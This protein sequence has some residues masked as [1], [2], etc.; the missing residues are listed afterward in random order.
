M[1]SFKR[2]P[3]TDLPLACEASGLIR[4]FDQLIAVGTENLR[5]SCKDLYV[6][7]QYNRALMI[8]P[9]PFRSVEFYYFSISV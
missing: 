1:D 6:H 2:H 8:L 4:P 7:V 3:I 5:G 9:Y